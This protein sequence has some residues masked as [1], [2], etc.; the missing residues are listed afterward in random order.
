LGL[1]CPETSGYVWINFTGRRQIHQSGD[2]GGSKY[3]VRAAIKREASEERD[4]SHSQPQFRRPFGTSPIVH[5][6]QSHFSWRTLQARL[7]QLNEWIGDE[8]ITFNPYSIA[9]ISTSPRFQ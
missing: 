5:P 9:D 2:Q 4:R 3:S 8:A 7:Q 1:V 6:A